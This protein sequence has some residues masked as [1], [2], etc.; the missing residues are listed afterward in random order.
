MKIDDMIG[1][2]FGRLL[3]MGKAPT[4]YTPNGSARTML[5]CLCDCG[6]VK[7]IYSGSIANGFTI[8]CGC[9]RREKSP[10]NGT[11]HGRS[12]TRIYNIWKGMNKRCRGKNPDYGGRGIKVCNEWQ[13]SFQ[14]F[15]DWAMANGYT[16]EL[17][18]DR[19]DVNGNYEPS[20]CRW[21]TREEQQNN[22]RD[23]VRVEFGGKVLTLS[24]WAQLHNINRSTLLN[25]IN[26][27]WEFERAI[28]EPVNTRGEK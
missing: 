13:D 18:I 23:N 12:K 7:Q 24:E 3:V 4:K 22:K 25:R 16:D 10:Y 21:A 17:S 8:S 9:Y 2:K 1:K 27:G 5:I 28:T 15:F 6:T 19:I 11:T 14:I 20:N 26:R